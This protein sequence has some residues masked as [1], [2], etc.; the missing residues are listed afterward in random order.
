MITGLP[1]LSMRIGDSVQAGRRGDVTVDPGSV[2][3]PRTTGRASPASFLGAARRGISPCL[4]SCAVAGL[5]EVLWTTIG[6]DPVV[7]GRGPEFEV[8]SGQ[9]RE[10]EFELTQEAFAAARK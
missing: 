2:A 4:V 9:Q 1:P 10:V 7:H 6:E 3:L 8:A 5:Y